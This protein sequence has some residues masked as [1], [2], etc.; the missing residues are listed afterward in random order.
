MATT[1]R[2]ARFTSDSRYTLTGAFTQFV[3][4]DHPAAR[5]PDRREERVFYGKEKLIAVTNVIIFVAVEN[6]RKQ[7]DCVDAISKRS[8]R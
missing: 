5:G 4:G 8:K 7:S 3:Y 1:P 2:D 6:N